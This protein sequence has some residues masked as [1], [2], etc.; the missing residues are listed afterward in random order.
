MRCPQG[1]SC[2]CTRPSHCAFRHI[3][4]VLPVAHDLLAGL[5]AWEAKAGRG[6]M[7]Y[8]FH[9]AVTSW[10]DRVAADMATAVSRH[11]VNSFKFF[12]AYKGALMVNDA[13]LLAGMRRCLALGALAMVHAENGEAVEDGRA[14]VFAA[15]V[16][17]PEGH[18]LSRPAAVE[19]EATGRAIRLAHLVDAPLYVVHVMAAGAA[20]QVAAARAAGQRVIGEAVLSGIALD[21]SAA[22]QPDFTAAAAAVMSPPIR[23]L[24]VDGAALAGALVGGVL[25]PLGTDHCAFNSSQKAAGRHDFRLIPNGVNGIGERMVVAWDALV[26]TGKATRSEY[27]RMTSTA[28]AHAFNLYPRKGVIAAGSDADVILFDP[29]GETTISA[30]THH[31]A[32][33]TNVYEGRTARGRVTHTLSRGRLAWADGVLRCEP[34]T[35]RFVPTPP[36]APTLFGGM[37]ERDKA[38]A[39]VHRPVARAGDEPAAAGQAH[40]EL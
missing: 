31:S 1:E 20:A 30:G 40:D 26:A 39:Q 3:D 35:S 7:D 23:R 10:S 12:M 38:R 28:A 18:A 24:A 4:F 17:G 37:A 9:V 29:A 16:T 25:G 2:A 11:G 6:C 27:V 22:Q 14:A 8:G 34:G 13:E 21:E 15:G 32:S 19:E 33:D 5:A 36:F